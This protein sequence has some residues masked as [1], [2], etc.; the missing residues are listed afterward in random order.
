MKSALTF[1]AQNII[2]QSFVFQ[3][4]NGKVPTTKAIKQKSVNKK[5]NN[6][7]IVFAFHLFFVPIIYL[8]FLYIFIFSNILI[9]THFFK[10]STDY[11]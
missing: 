6:A 2:F 4:Y 8:S 7:I 3:K 9:L 5:H 10:Q 1:C 11:L